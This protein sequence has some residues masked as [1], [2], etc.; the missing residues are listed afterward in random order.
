MTFGSVLKK[1]GKVAAAPVVY[2]A[3]AISKGVNGVVKTII[4]KVIR[5]GL[6]AVG[7]YLMTNG[8]L[9]MAQWD[10]AIG[11]IVLL[12]SLAWSIVPALLAKRKLAAP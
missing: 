2:P 5:H 1:I 6:G 12:V 11:A 4:E 8:Y 3:K 7:T 9:D 10:Q